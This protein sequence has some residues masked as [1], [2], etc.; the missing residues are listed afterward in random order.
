MVEAETDR[1]AL[2]MKVGI[3]GRFAKT[4]LGIQHRF[5]PVAANRAFAAEIEYGKEQHASL[6]INPEMLAVGL[7]VDLA[8][9]K[10]LVAFA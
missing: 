5:D 2:A 1:I 4:L 10:H 3:G 9:A 7:P 8:A 6:A